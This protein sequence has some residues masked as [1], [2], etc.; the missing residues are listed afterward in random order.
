MAGCSRRDE[1]KALLKGVIRE[2]V[3]EELDP[4][5]VAAKAEETAKSE[6]ENKL[7]REEELKELLARAK[8]RGI[9][10]QARLAEEEKVKSEKRAE[11]LSYFERNQPKDDDEGDSEGEGD[12]K[13]GSSDKD[14]PKKDGD[15]DDD[16]DDDRLA[17]V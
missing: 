1:V 3:D 7:E 10:T 11:R 4:T 16:D 13:G 15:D 8:Q 12:A 5:E 9:E 6:E 2:S 14:K 17:L